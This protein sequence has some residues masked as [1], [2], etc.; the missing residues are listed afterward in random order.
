VKRLICQLSLAILCPLTA[1]WAQ[2]LPP[3]ETGISL[4]Q[5][6]TI[7]RDM[8]SAKKFWTLLGATPIS[9]DGTEVMKFAGVLVF[10]TPGSPSG[11]TEGTVVDHVGFGVPDVRKTLAKLKAEG[12]KVREP[13]PNGSPL[14]GLPVGDA[15]S[16]DNLMVELE[17]VQTLTTPCP[18]VACIPYLNKWSA[19]EI[20]SNHIHFHVPVTIRNQMQDWYAKM[21]GATPGVLGDNLTGDIPGSRFIRWTAKVPAGETT[22][23]T[24]GRALDYIG[25]EVRNLEAFCKKLEV[26]GVKF[27]APYSKT[28]HKS[29]A[30]A[31]LTDPWGVSIELTEGLN[32]F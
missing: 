24:K 27:D 25:F 5:W 6:H 3:N 4:G 9:V 16:P 29:F 14:N 20:A 11:G 22:L 23:P 18:I 19:I 21:F 13:G 12:I 15:W 8:D 26:K 1:S 17:T 28:R 32:R 31:Q 10:L 2:V 30:S 7:V